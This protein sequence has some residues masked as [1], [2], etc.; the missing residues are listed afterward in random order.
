MRRDDNDT[1]AARRLTLPHDSDAA[2]NRII[3]A[4]DNSVGG[5]DFD[6]LGHA[7]WKWVTE[8]DTGTDPGDDTFDYLKALDNSSLTIAGEPGATAEKPTAGSAGDGYNPYDTV[9]MP[10]PFRPRRR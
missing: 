1:S 3:A 8:G 10:S 7:R 2:E 9:N 5:I 6:D 4:G